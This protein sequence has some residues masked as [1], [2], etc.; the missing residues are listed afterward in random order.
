MLPRAP[1]S[2]PRLIILSSRANMGKLIKSASKPAKICIF[3]I[4]FSRMICW[5]RCRREFLFCLNFAAEFRVEEELRRAHVNWP[6]S[7]TGDGSQTAGKVVQD[8]GCSVADHSVAIAIL[9]P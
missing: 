9:R 7:R 3:R 4:Q 1:G 8:I 2:R 6:G 5:L